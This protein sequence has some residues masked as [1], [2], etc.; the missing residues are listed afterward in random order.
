MDNLQD[1]YKENRKLISEYIE[2]RIQI[3]RLT[4]VRS[5]SKTLSMLILLMVISLMVL[6]FFVFLVIAFSIYIGN[7]MENPVMGFLAGAGVFLVVLL[8]SILFRKPLFLNPLIRLFILT[9]ANEEEEEEDE[10]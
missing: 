6:L 8:L 5:L 9:T 2:T 1:F 3:L 10:E 7:Q 4:S